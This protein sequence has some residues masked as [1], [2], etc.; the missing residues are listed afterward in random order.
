VLSLIQSLPELGK[1]TAVGGQAEFFEALATTTTLAG[2]AIVGLFRQGA[3]ATA[4]NAAGIYTNNN[5]P[6]GP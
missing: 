6:F 3:T 4:L 2:Q 5:I 1:D